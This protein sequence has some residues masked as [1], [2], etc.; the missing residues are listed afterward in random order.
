[1]MGLPRSSAF[2]SFSLISS[3]VRAS[4][5]TSGNV[6][7][8]GAF[9]IG[10]GKLALSLLK[11]SRRSTACNKRMH[12]FIEKKLYWNIRRVAKEQKITCLSALLALS[13][14]TTSKV[15]ILLSVCPSKSANPYCSQVITNTIAV[16]P[17]CH[18]EWE[19]YRMLI[20]SYMDLSEKY[21]NHFRF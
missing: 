9:G 20:P 8:E 11:A 19:H 5:G 1:M 3:C 6:T 18:A 13:S 16:Q 17:Q 7:N 21:A 2:F 4:G 10:C 12:K 14:S 15:R